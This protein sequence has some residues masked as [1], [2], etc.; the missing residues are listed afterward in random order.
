MLS[1]FNQDDSLPSSLETDDNTDSIY[2]F[3]LLFWA[4]INNYHLYKVYS[5][6]KAWSF[7]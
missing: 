2:F 1:G 3:S 5:I 7:Q 6:Y 4:N